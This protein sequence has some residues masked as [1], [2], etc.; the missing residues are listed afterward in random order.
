MSEFD[1]RNPEKFGP[2]SPTV[3]QAEPASL[4]REV[5]RTYLEISSVTQLV[6]GRPPSVS[7]TLHRIDPCTVDAWRALYRQIGAPWHW[8]DRDSWDQRAMAA[9]LERPEVRV[10]RV[11]A[12]LGQVWT[13]DV[14]FLELERHSD[15]SIEIAYIGLDQRVLGRRLGGWLVA[16]AVQTA[17]AWGAVRV[18]LHTC[19]LDAPAALPNYLARG[20]VV[21]RVETYDRSIPLN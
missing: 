13:D 9:H 3:G 21:T 15:G 16:Q 20:F 5:T 14:G 6:S 17:F 4:R 11:E 19:S 10:Y 1:R 8:H 12:E 2:I 7:A 18:W